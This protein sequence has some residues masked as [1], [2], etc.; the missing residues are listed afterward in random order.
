[1]RI[2]CVFSFGNLGANDDQPGLL[3]ALHEEER[4][5]VANKNGKLYS[6]H[7]SQVRINMGQP[8]TRSITVAVKP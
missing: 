5:T 2:P 1:M 4:A 7:I 6:V 8:F 3:I